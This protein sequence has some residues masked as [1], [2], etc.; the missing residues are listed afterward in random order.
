MTSELLQL[1]CAGRR[2]KE[3]KKTA[4]YRPKLV[5]HIKKQ[6]LEIKFML[7]DE[8]ISITELILR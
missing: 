4:L 5:Y 1:V 8:T 2:K 6:E 7:F 3:S